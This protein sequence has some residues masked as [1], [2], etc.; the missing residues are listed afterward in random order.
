MARILVVDDKQMLRDS[1]TATLVRGGHKAIAAS[2]GEAAIAMIAKHRPDVVVTDLKMPGM[3]GIELL[4]QI[5]EFD[6]QLPVILMTAYA[7]IDTAV[8]AMKHGAFDYIQKPFEGDT[9][10]LVVKRAVEHYAL[11]TEN[12]A[13]RSDT[14]QQ[15]RSR[16]LIGMSPLM[17]QLRQQIEQIAAS[18]SAVLISGESGTGKEIVAQLVHALS[19]RRG[20]VCLCV[21]CAALSRNLLESELFGHEKGA[22]TG[23]DKLRKGRFELAEGGTILLDEISEM[24]PDIQ[25]KLLRVLQERQFERVGSSTTIDVNVRVIATTNRDLNHAVS[26]GA[27]RQDLYFRLNVLPLHVPPLRQRREDIRELA[28]HFLVQQALRDGRTPRE[29]DDEATRI[30]TAYD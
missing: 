12:E 21:N 23:A 11:R 19:L 3:D 25:A 16:Q 30:L 6:P 7:T 26:T 10:I 15:V 13:L 2:D 22:F 4:G 1:V 18:D 24:D 17:I 14:S 28:D 27:F 5:A 20:K 8:R 9:L 29:F